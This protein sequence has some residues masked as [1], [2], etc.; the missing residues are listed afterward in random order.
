MKSIFFAP[1]QGYTEDAYRRIHSVLAGGVE[2]YY[3]PFLRVEHGRL[4]SKDVRDVNPEYNSG[5]NLVPQIIASSEA[6]VETLLRH[7]S[8]LGVYRHVDLNMGCPF[9]LQARH[10]RGAGLLPCPEKSGEV[11]GAMKR[12]CEAE[13]L[14]FSVKMRLGLESPDEWK[15]ILPLIEGAGAEYVTVHP[16]I[17]TQQ[18]KGELYL[19]SFA[20]FC[21]QC[22]LPVVYNGDV[23]SLDD[24]KRVED[25]YPE[26][27]A[28][29]IGR[30]LLARPSLA[31][32]YADG[33]EWDR[34]RRMELV[35]EMYR[36]FYAHHESVIPGEVQLLSKVRSFWEYMEEELGRKAYKKI[37]KAGNMKNYARAVDEA[38]RG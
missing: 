9:P 28:I 8:S 4:R 21:T 29:M 27:K 20:E 31:A 34:R 2:A 7:V 24:I 11:L 13:G 1:L 33:A 12:F 19:D 18:Y 37:M 35:A 17:G 15:Q 32:E 6:E 14:T 30:G 10:G 25:A 16:R 38:L 5:V 36:R 22:S 26:L 23:L 3:S